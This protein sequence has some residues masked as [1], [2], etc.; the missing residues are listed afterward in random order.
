MPVLN[1][2]CVYVPAVRPEA[3]QAPSLGGRR[4]SLWGDGH[5]N[6]SQYTGSLHMS[7]REGV[8]KSV[9]ERG[10]IKRREETVLLRRLLL[11]V[12]S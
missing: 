7:A 9:R 10:R 11:I 6:L 3:W 2:E 12:Q 1:R 5:A 8:S 4:G